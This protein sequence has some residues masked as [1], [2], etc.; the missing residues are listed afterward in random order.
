MAG[1]F[2]SFLG[3]AAG[4]AT[5]A[6]VIKA[7]DE[8]SKELAKASS[9]TEASAKNMS[10]NFALSATA[11]GAVSA[12][13]ITLGVEAGRAEGIG[14]AFSH[15]YGNV[16]PQALKELERATGGAVSEME[17]MAAANQA[18]LLGIDPEALPAMFKGAYAV[19][20]AT[21]R[22]VAMAIDDISLGIARQ[23]KLILDNLGIIVDVEKANERYAASL[24]KTSS[25]LSDA[26]R[27]I[28]FTNAAMD[29]LKTNTDKVGGATENAATQMQRLTAEWKNFK[30]TS[31]EAVS[32][33]LAF[34]LG[35]AA[36]LVS[37]ASSV[38]DKISGVYD[39][40]KY[41][42]GGGADYA[43]N[44]PELLIM[45]RKIAYQKEGLKGNE[46]EARVRN[47]IGMSMREEVNLYDMLVSSTQTQE[48]SVTSIASEVDKINV[49][50]EEEISKREAT[51]EQSF[52]QWVAEQGK[53]VENQEQLELLRL[54]YAEQEKITSQMKTQSSLFAKLKAGS[55]YLSGKSDTE[56]QQTVYSN[57]KPIGSNIKFNDFLMRPGSAPVS[58]SEQD[59]IIGVK[60]PGKLGGGTV[61][62][63]I[64]SVQGLD[65]EAVADALEKKVMNSIVA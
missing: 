65:S 42:L 60:N 2:D 15:M 22:P 51:K 47:L 19:S 12:A 46:A 59:T 56:I 26:E 7:Y 55:S 8:Y 35:G 29:A 64:D 45:A 62:I 53:T 39:K 50:I 23:S 24:G 58:F 44:N 57:K 27:K 17:L 1:A 48:K 49:L 16:A 9:K 31:G 34:L 21:G 38:G 54:Q 6:I 10:K 33:P 11:A 43:Q 41:N 37:D 30:Q 14:R 28:A 25:Q 18:L 3:G 13:I 61:N 36:S 5:V 40:S 20:Q 32:G 52:V 63:Y 4:G